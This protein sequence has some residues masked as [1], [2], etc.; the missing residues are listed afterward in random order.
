MEI[1]KKKRGR[2][3]GT[4]AP[5]TK[6]V[7]KRKRGRPKGTG[8]NKR[9][10][11]SWN[12]NENMKPGDRGRYIRHAMA[13]W[14]LPPIDISDPE[15][16]NERIIWYFNQCATDDMKPTV[17]G[18]ANALGVRRQTLYKWC[19]GECRAA[20]HK[21]LLEKAYKT[22]ETLMESWMADGKVNPVVGIFLSKNHFGYKDQQDLAIAPSSPL[23]DV[24]DPEEV[25]QRYM[26]SIVYDEPEAITDG[27]EKEEN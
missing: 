2:P 18:L 15:Q 9:P 21:D 1:E 8:G 23:G 27:K 16:V 3:K 11:L 24:K 10:D 20:T 22:L 19:M 25:R 4:I 13:S 7:E 14:G 6:E 5:E 17:S 12:G 26:D